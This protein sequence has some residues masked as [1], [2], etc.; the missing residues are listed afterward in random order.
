MTISIDPHRKIQHFD[1]YCYKNAQSI[2]DKKWSV[3]NSKAKWGMWYFNFP[4]RKNDRWKIPKQ[5]WSEIILSP[6]RQTESMI[7]YDHR[8]IAAKND[9]CKIPKQ[10]EGCDI[11]QN[12]GRGMWFFQNTG[13]GMWYF[14][15][16]P[17][18]KMIGA[19]FQSK[20]WKI[21][22]S[23]GRQNESMIRYDHREIENE[24]C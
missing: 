16:P 10:N 11:S 13:R 18:K 1:G 17:Q 15:F 23:P 2:T 4:P 5:K 12:T 7:R 20:I 6:G 19:K 24:G 14:K 21:I 8:K 9:R 22:L 3:E